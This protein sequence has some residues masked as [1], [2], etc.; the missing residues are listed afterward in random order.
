[1]PK[2]SNVV[3]FRVKPDA[4]EAFVGAFETAP[5]FEGLQTHFLIKTGEHTYCSCGVWDSQES[6]VAARPH[7]IAF[8]DTA[9]GHLEE[10]SPELGVTDPVSGTVVFEQSA[11]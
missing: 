7:M 9:R 8:L 3:R 6:L 11:G 4:H 1:M 10:I 2:F 5:S